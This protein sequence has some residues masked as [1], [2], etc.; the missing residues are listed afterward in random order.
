MVRGTE[1]IG[2]REV[3]ARRSSEDV[4]EHAPEDPTEPRSAP[5]NRLVGGKDDRD[6]E[7]TRN[8]NKT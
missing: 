1:P 3:G 8:L 2:R 6:I 4:G 5:L 7:L